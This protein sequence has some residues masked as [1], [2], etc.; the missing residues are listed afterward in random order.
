MMIFMS[1]SS[2]STCCWSPI[3]GIISLIFV[4]FSSCVCV[5]ILV[6]HYQKP[7]LA[8]INRKGECVIRISG[9]YGT[10][11]FFFCLIP[12]PL[13]AFASFCRH[14]KDRICL[15]CISKACMLQVLSYEKP[16]SLWCSLSLSLS[17]SAPSSLIYFQLFTFTCL[18][19]H[20]LPTPRFLRKRLQL[21]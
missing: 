19:S 13:H 15:P 1:M 11:V 10:R 5:K 6:F 16:T 9:M 3:L 18:L 14:V 4:Y 8:G 7:N 21:D 12:A 2:L 17:L 20:S